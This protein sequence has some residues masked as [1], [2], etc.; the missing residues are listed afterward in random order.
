MPTYEYTCKECNHV[1]EVE[2]SIQNSPLKHCERC[3]KDTAVRLISAGTG[4]I[5]TGGGWAAT[6]YSK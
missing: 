4:F 3:K 1:W 5:L 2:H 6:N